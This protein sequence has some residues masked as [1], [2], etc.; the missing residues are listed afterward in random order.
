[1]SEVVTTHPEP[2]AD[3]AAC[4]VGNE[5]MQAR[6]TIRDQTQLQRLDHAT[7]AGSDHQSPAPSEAPRLQ[8]SAEGH[9]Q[10]QV[11]EDVREVT[12]VEDSVDRA[13][14]VTAPDRRVGRKERE[15]PDRGEAAPQQ[16]A[17]NDRVV[18]AWPAQ[19]S[20]LGQ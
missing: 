5:V 3:Q 2:P 10:Q 11:E 4:G 1:M 9:E 6:I 15:Q 14:A 19:R 18:V 8:S 20:G 16:E 12:G 17:S 13:R 7:D